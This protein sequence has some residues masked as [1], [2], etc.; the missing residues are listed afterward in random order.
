MSLINDAAIYKDAITS[1]PDLADVG[2][3]V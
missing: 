2:N 3:H 1:S